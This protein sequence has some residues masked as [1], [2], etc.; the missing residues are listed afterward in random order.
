MMVEISGSWTKNTWRV[1][2]DAILQRVMQADW[3]KFRLL[4]SFESRMWINGFI[5]IFD[6]SVM[7]IFES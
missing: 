6:F 3:I 4:I 1:G 2:F 7:G 5:L